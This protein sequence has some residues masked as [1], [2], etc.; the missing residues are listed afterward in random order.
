MRALPLEPSAH[1]S[2]DGWQG[3]LRMERAMRVN[4]MRQDITRANRHADKN[5][6]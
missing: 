4:A 2:D 5:G 6:G 3:M 1:L